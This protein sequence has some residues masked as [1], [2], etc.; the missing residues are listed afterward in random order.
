MSKEPLS[1]EEIARLR[2]TANWVRFAIEPH[3][4]TGPCTM[5]ADDAARVAD[6]AALALRLLPDDHPGG[7]PDDMPWCESCRSYHAVPRDGQHRYEL[8]CRA[9]VPLSEQQRDLA[10]RTLVAW[11]DEPDCPLKRAVVREAER[12]LR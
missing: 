2:A 8:G 11:R 3:D 4:N 12:V 7:L 6:M 10:Q 9:A 5:A 1:D